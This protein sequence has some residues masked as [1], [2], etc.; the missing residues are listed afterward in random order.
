MVNL[1]EVPS[2]TVCLLA[3]CLICC[4][5]GACSCAR[6]YTGFS[7]LPFVAWRPPNK[8]QSH[9]EYRLLPLCV[10]GTGP[11]E[12]GL[13]RLAAARGLPHGA[14]AERV[15]GHGIGGAVLVLQD[16]VPRRPA[17][18]PPP[19]GR[20]RFPHPPPHRHPFRRLDPTARSP[21]P[22]RRISCATRHQ[23]GSQSTPN[24]P[25]PNTHF[26]HVYIISAEGGWAA[27]SPHGRA[28]GGYHCMAAVG[29][30]VLSPHVLWKYAPERTSVWQVTTIRLR[31]AGK[32]WRLRISLENCRYFEE[33]SANF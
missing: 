10:L 32:R 5:T 22:R 6:G 4:R 13:G 11:P 23:I 21:G 2:T 7:L 8:R 19:P 3:A 28:R 27:G 17:P 24:P 33:G 16:C 14:G 15:H 18:I 25:T 29:R 1:P 12:G 30:S 26:A 9:A 20:P 31:L